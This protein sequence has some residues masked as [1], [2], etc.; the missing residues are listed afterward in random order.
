[1]LTHCLCFASI[2]AP[3]SSLQHTFSDV[4]NP[5]QP[6]RNAEAGDGFEGFDQSDEYTGS[7]TTDANMLTGSYN[8]TEGACLATRE[9]ER[10]RERE[11]VC[12]CGGGCVEGVG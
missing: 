3:V 9:R 12:V 6:P 1:M 5:F 7:D 10:E 4:F 2:A 11:D 8:I